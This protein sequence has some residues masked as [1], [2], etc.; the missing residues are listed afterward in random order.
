ML[1][2]V[3]IWEPS[4]DH[5]NRVGNTDGWKC[6]ERPLVSMISQMIK[7]KAS[8]PHEIIRAQLPTP[9]QVIEALT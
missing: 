7:A 8:V 4:V 3:Q 1:Y 5:H 9:P 2:G 6:M